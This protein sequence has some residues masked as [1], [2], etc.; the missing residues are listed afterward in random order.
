MGDFIGSNKGQRNYKLWLIPIICCLLTVFLMIFVAKVKDN[1]IQCKIIYDFSHEF[2]YEPYLLI[3]G[4][5]GNHYEIRPQ[6]PEDDTF[7]IIYSVFEERYTIPYE[8]IPAKSFSLQ[9]LN[10]GQESR[11][12]SIEF[13]NHG[14]QI[15]KYSSGDIQE[16]FDTSQWETKVYNTYICIKHEGRIQLPAKELFYHELA[17]YPYRNQPLYW[18]SIFWGCIVGLLVFALLYR[19]GINS[20]IYS[21]NDKNKKLTKWEIALAFGLLIVFVLVCGMS[22]FSKHYSHPDETVTRMATDYYLAGW[23]RPDM[24]SSMVSGT[25]SMWGHNRLT[26]ANLYYFFAGKIGWIFRE[27]FSIPTYYRMFNLLLFGVMLIFCWKK[28]KSHIWAVVA[29]CMTPQIWYLFS[30]ATSDAWDWFCG[31][32]MIFMI[33]QKE[34]YLYDQDNM[35]QLVI[36]GLIYS[37]IFAMILLGKSNYLVL[38]GIAFVDFL[39]GWFQQKTGKLRI[40]IIYIAILAASF[41]IKLGIEHLPTAKSEIVFSE[42]NDNLQAGIKAERKGENQ[43]VSLGHPKAQGIPFSELALP[44]LRTIFQSAN[45]YY[46]WMT[47]KSGTIYYVVIGLIHLTFL[48]IMINTV[49]KNRRRNL[50]VNI[51]SAYLLFSFFL[52]ILVVLLYCWMVT[53]QP[54]GRYLLMVWLFMGYLCAQYKDVFD[55]RALKGTITASICAGFWSFGY[56]GIFTMLRNGCLFVSYQKIVNILGLFFGK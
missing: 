20:V 53:Y 27:F 46:M 44:T 1:T 17:E 41:G 32:V 3:E 52:M 8:A 36:N 26:E 54:Q 4:Q 24:N 45:G 5:N 14:Y 11:I 49:W 37:F 50:I 34:K 55:S 10:S 25:F 33:L 19:S 39:L 2:G 9:L 22:F 42:P 12:C 31:F 23:L 13:Y 56:Y 16:L 38:L 40:F 48:A 51:K 21:S 47:Y 29:L 28:R 43:G 35:K 18:N 6:V 7:Q 30:Y 15:A